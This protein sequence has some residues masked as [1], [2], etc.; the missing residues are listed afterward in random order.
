MSQGPIVQDWNEIVLRKK[1]T[2]Q[3]QIRDGEVKT[4][5]KKTSNKKNNQIIGSRAANDFDPEN[6]E[7]LVTSNRDLGIAIMNAR[8]A[9][10][11]KQSDLDQRCNFPKN[12][13][14]NY[15]N[16]KAT[17]VPSQINTLERVLGVKLPRPKKK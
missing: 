16:G 11:M 8:N 7:K 3:E 17:V 2:K 10:N 6:I 9:K 12:T 5:T 1:K 14:Q 4:V 15:E 13:V